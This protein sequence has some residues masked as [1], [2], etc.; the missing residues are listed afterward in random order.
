VSA[1]LDQKTF[2]ILTRKTEAEKG[3]KKWISEEASKVRTDSYG[4]GYPRG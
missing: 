2:D 1:V 3:S 4:V